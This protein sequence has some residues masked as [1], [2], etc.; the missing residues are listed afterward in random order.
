MLHKKLS[1]SSYS[2]MFIL[3]LKILFNPESSPTS[4]PNL[5]VFHELK[6]VH[7]TSTIY[8]VKKT[9]LFWK[10]T[11]VLSIEKVTKSTLDKV[12]VG[13]LILNILYIKADQISSCRENITDAIQ[14][15]REQGTPI[16][17][18]GKESISKVFG[19]SIFYKYHRTPLFNCVFKLIGLRNNRSFPWSNF[20]FESIYV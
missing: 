14:V 15:Q 5:W 4:N 20:F 17:N 10:Q 16:N 2:E 7:L 6:K 8:Y 19:A 13:M 11:Q 9:I 18:K 3:I 12:L 1:V